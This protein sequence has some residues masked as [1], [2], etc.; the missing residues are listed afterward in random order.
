MNANGSTPPNGKP[1]H[2]LEWFVASLLQ[3]TAQIQ[4]IV[5]HMLR[6][7]AETGIV[8]ETTIDESL[9]RLLTDTLRR[10][11]KRA[12]GEYAAAAALL[13]D[14]SEVIENEIYLVEPGSVR[15]ELGDELTEPP[16]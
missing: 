6:F 5:H 9:R 10:G 12:P 13:D 7:E 1:T 3:S 11:L 4:L 16:E 15:S 14:T 8:P 2:P